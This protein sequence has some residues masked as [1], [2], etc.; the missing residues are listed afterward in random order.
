MGFSRAAQLTLQKCPEGQSHM[1]GFLLVAV[2]TPE[3]EENW[4]WSEKLLMFGVGG[5]HDT[6]Y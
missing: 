4:D 3:M 2:A 5:G 1:L 6:N